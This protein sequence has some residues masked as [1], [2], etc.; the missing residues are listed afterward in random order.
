MGPLQRGRMNTGWDQEAEKSATFRT[1]L[2]V[3][4]NI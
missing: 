4:T 2:V 1:S 3:F